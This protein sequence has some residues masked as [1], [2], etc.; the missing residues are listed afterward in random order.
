[1]VRALAMLMS[2]TIANEAHRLSACSCWTHPSIAAWFS[3]L[4]FLSIIVIFTPSFSYPLL[5]SRFGAQDHVLPAHLLYSLCHQICASR[6]CTIIISIILSLILLICWLVPCFASPHL[7]TAITS[8]NSPAPT[9]RMERIT[10]LFVAQSVFHC[11]KRTKKENKN[12]DPRRETS[13]RHCLKSWEKA[14]GSSLLPLQGHRCHRLSQILL[15]NTVRGLFFFWEPGFEPWLVASQ[16]EDFPPC[17]KHVLVERHNSFIMFFFWDITCSFFLRYNLFFW[18][19]TQ[20][21]MLSLSI[22]NIVK[23]CRPSKSMQSI[24]NLCAKTFWEV[25]VGSNLNLHATS[26][27]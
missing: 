12:L 23:L 11:W 18:C 3:P 25:S 26:V 27:T 13:R 5:S 2:S 20:L 8:P 10:L 15:G 4:I 21:L 17:Y 19:S 22:Q 1:M 6:V 24:L 16:L 14:P 9:T 7:P